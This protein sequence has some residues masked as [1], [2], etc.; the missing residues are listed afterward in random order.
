[1]EG[2]AGGRWGILDVDNIGG[3]TS[4][5]TKRN[6]EM[7]KYS[8]CKIHPPK[9]GPASHQTFIPRLACPQF[10]SLLPLIELWLGD[11]ETQIFRASP[12][13]RKNPPG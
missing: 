10:V 9:F 12:R 5:G 11:T 1:M 3:R 7:I 8:F 2:M 4:G 6:W 13:S